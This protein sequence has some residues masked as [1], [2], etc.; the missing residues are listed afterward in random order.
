MKEPTNYRPISLLPIVSKLLERHVYNVIMNHLVHHNPLTM[1]QWGFLKGR[2]TVTSLLY[3]TDHWLKELED[4]CAVFFDFRKAFDSV[5]HLP[6]MCKVHSLGLDANIVTW[7]NN[8]LV[9]RTQ[10]V[11]VNGSES[12]TISVVSGVPQ[13]SVLG[14]LLFLVYIDDLPDTLAN[15]CSN[16][17]LFADD[18]LL[19]HIIAKEAD[20]EALQS[21][22][23]LI[24]SSS[25]LTPPNANT[26]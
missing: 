12:S 9:K 17:N 3:V 5:P 16:V 26:W 21:A 15:I 10:A 20:Y 22:I 25:T 23:S 11:V 8:Y 6:L 24:S 2:S 18:V 7:I 19:Y 13:G 14:P 4:I 1:N